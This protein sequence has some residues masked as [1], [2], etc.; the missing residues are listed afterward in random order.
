MR[1]LSFNGFAKHLTDDLFKVVSVCRH[2]ERLTLPGADNLTSASLVH[3]FS[4]LRELVI[5][6]LSGVQAVNDEVLRHIAHSSV[7][8]Q[9][10]NFSKCGMVGDAGV[11]AMASKLTMLRRV[12]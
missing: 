10:L 5:I 2:L 7:M 9:G 1:R 8:V 6:D 3:V 4:R 12:S 11:L